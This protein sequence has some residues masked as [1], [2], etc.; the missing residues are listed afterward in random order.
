MVVGVNNS[1]KAALGYF[2][3]VSATADILF[4]LMWQAVAYLEQAGL[5]VS[6]LCSIVNLVN[7]NNSFIYTYDTGPR[8][9]NVMMIDWS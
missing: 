9:S 7:C 1:I 4:P 5:R 3:T 2:P 8:C 6:T